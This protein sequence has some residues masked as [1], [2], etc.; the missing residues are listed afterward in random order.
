M[1][2]SLK[3]VV[4]LLLILCC[5]LVSYV[6][7]RKPFNTVSPVQ[8][9]SVIDAKHIPNWMTYT[10]KTYALRFQYPKTFRV[11]ESAEENVN[12]GKRIFVDFSQTNGQPIHWL[13]ISFIDQKNIQN[14]L[15]LKVGE[16]YIDKTK[17]SFIIN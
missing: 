6:L 5:I 4:I 16:T 15:S 7:L 3:Y 10:S 2:N 12:L 9:T 11:N 1:K 17:A 13:D 8:T 14:L